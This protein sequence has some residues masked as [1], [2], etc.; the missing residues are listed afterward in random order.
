MIRAFTSGMEGMKAQQAAVDVIANN[1]ANVNTTGFASQNVRF[2][3]LLHSSLREPADP[4]Y[5]RT[6]TG[7]GVKAAAVSADMSPGTPVE[8]DRALDYSP[9]A[10]GFFAVMGGDGTVRYTRDGS[11]SV[12]SQADGRYLVNAK[13]LSVLGADGVRIAVDADGKPLAAPGVFTFSNAAGLRAAGDGLYETTDSSGAATV[14]EEGARSGYL[15][16]SNVDLAGQMTGLIESQRGYQLDS[17]VI[18]TADQV[19]DWTNNL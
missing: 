3:D 19:A 17:R 14:S 16:G 15:M 10:D 18:Q 12:G 2:S 8:T 5:A 9:E 7:N 6:L 1:V 4:D 13:G 11:F